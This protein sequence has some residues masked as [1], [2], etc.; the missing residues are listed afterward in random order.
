M[1]GGGGGRPWGV[2]GG[3]AAGQRRVQ[4]KLAGLENWRVGRGC[5]LICSCFQ[6][7][8]PARS[9]PP[10]ASLASFAYSLGFDPSKIQNV[11]EKETTIGSPCFEFF[12]FGSNVI[13]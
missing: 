4:G 13:L 11:M 8:L 3:Q 5:I 2:R 9:G 7:R 1:R 6:H 12:Q 10:S